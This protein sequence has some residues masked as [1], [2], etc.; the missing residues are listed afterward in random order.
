MASKHCDGLHKPR[1]GNLSAPAAA[2][3]YQISDALT[4]VKGTHNYKIGGECDTAAAGRTRHL[5]TGPSAS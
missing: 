2:T 5:P 3:G 4:I 1:L